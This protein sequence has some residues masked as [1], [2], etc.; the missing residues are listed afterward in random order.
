MIFFFLIPCLQHQ[1]I[2]RP[3]SNSGQCLFPLYWIDWWIGWLIDWKGLG[4]RGLLPT[5]SLL[6]YSVSGRSQKPRTSSRSLTWAT[7]PPVLG[8]S[9]LPPWVCLSRKLESKEDTAVEL[10]LSDTLC[11]ALNGK[12]SPNSALTALK[13]WKEKILG[14]H[15]I[16]YLFL[17]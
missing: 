11:C 8:S 14:K 9:L 12:A 2:H 7:G 4:E 5:R 3:V 6:K 10:N 1:Q 13:L 16:C 17:E 15:S